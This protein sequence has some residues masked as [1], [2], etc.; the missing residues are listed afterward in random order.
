M[1]YHEKIFL[2]EPDRQQLLFPLGSPL[3][4]YQGVKENLVSH[5]WVWVDIAEEGWRPDWN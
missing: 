1:I 2:K 4:F 3:L 5:S